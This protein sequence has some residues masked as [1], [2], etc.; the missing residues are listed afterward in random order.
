LPSCL[1]ARLPALLQT[2][3]NAPCLKVKNSMPFAEK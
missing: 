2:D 3:S 1:P